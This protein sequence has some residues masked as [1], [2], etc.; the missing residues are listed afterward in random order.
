MINYFGKIDRYGKCLDLGIDCTGLGLCNSK[1]IV[2]LHG[3]EIW[4]ESGGR[5]KVLQD[6]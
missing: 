1:K 6:N 4:V 5:N 2:E 3:E